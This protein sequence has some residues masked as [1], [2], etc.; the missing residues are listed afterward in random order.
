MM[1]WNAK[2]IW[3]M[4]AFLAGLGSAPVHS[5]EN[6]AMMR[7]KNGDILVGTLL[8]STS[9]R[10]R[11]ASAIFTSALA[12]DAKALESIMF[13]DVT[14]RPT[15]AFRMVT[16][17]GDV[18]VA[19]LVGS[20]EKSFHV[21][22]QRYGR[23][24]VNRDAVYTL[25]RRIHPNR[26]FDGSWISNWDVALDGPVKES[27]YK[28]YAGDWIA[29]DEDGF[30]VWSQLRP[31]EIGRLPN[32]YLDVDLPRFRDRFAILFEGRIDITDAGAYYCGM[33]ADEKARMFIDGQ[34]VAQA[35]AEDVARE[36]FEGVIDIENRPKVK[37]SPGPHSLRVEYFNSAGHTRLNAWI[38]G[39]DSPYL[40]L[41][42]INKGPGWYGGPGGRPQ[43][44]RKQAVLSQTI[45]M[46]KQFEIDLELVSSA[47]PQFVVAL[48]QDAW[49]ATSNQLLRLETRAD[50]L[51]VVQ[52][53][54]L[55]PVMTLAEDRRSIHLR[56][57]CDGDLG[58]LQVFDASG[59]LLV[60]VQGIQWPSGTSVIYIRNRGEDLAVRRLSIYP[61]FKRAAGQ[62]IDPMQPRVLLVDGQTICGHL[63][64]AEDGA[65]VVDQNGTRRGLDLDEVDSISGPGG[66]GEATPKAAELVYIDGEVVGGSIERV[67]SDHVVLRTAFSA[68]PVTC[69]LN[70]ASSL[71]FGWPPESTS[72]SRRS[73]RLFCALG[74]LHG[75]LSFDLGGSPLSWKPEGDTPPVGLAVTSGARVERNNRALAKEPFID[76]KAFPCVLHLRKGEIIPCRISF[77]D[78]NTLGF[79]S[80]F[81]KSRKIDSEHI[82]AIEFKPVEEGRSSYAL[83]DWL[84]ETLGTKSESLVAMDPMKLD[85]ALTVPRFHRNK[86]PTH[87]L[88]ARNGDLMRGTLLGISA[89]S[90]HFESRLRKQ[91][92]PI[93]RL[94]YVVCVSRPDEERGGP[95]KNA[96]DPGDRVRARLA[97][98][99]ILIF[100]PMV[101]RDGTLY[102]RSVI[103]GEMTVPVAYIEELNLGAFGEESF[104]SRF[105]DWV[106]H[107]AQEPRFTKPPPVTN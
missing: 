101:A 83:D 31:I 24:L 68:A 7:W 62:V 26:I 64:L 67:G 105:R 79:Q 52:D 90:V 86:P 76:E 32:G 72:P 71:R 30:P 33:S 102:G 97:Q 69:S 81:L 19:D 54:V 73:D 9:D 87:I 22:S 2:R 35:E 37:L 46:P 16:V 4:V 8:D 96:A 98:G 21:S 65:H 53:K 17:A 43:S 78:G 5:Q 10:I 84:R 58:Q 42:G 95:S 104:P 93:D 41:D 66:A 49:G 6:R 14:E 40:S 56:L 27:S 106:V 34:C 12:V 51:V 50:E 70:G 100:D 99:S 47:S 74:Q 88:V 107:P 75:Q 57:V 103:H 36:E 39:P 23:V 25:N 11:W 92:I 28:L 38:S 15:E 63:V 44:M 13:V 20:D 94:A 45:S 91:M 48:G 60:R 18:F 55:E 1:N 82:K 3:V 80:P 61:R 89:S 59:H 29:E 77:Y 85:H